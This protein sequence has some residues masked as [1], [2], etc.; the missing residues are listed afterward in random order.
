MGQAK[1]LVDD[2][3]GVKLPV[4][5]PLSDVVLP[6]DKQT[7]KQHNTTTIRKNNKKKKNRQKT[8][9]KSKHTCGLMRKKWGRRKILVDGDVADKL[10][11][12]NPLSDVVLPPDKQANSTTQQQ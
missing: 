2:D 7:S 12:S 11:G 9:N 4:S 5:K 1:I 8:N 6:P 10:S 3:A